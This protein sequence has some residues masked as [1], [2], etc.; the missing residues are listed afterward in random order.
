M[1]KH[2]SA[3]CLF[4]HRQLNFSSNTMQLNSFFNFQLNYHQPINCWDDPLADHW[5][6]IISIIATT[7]SRKYEETPREDWIAEKRFRKINTIQSFNVS[8]SLPASMLRNIFPPTIAELTLVGTLS[9]S[10]DALLR[11]TCHGILLYLL[12]SYSYFSLRDLWWILTLGRP[13]LDTTYSFDD[14]DLW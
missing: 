7:L 2:G 1:A 9:Y 4:F 10:A 3:L 11:E 13:V 14:G 5:S 12:F 8:F 6:V